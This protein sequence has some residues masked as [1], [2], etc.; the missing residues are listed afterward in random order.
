MCSNGCPKLLKQH[1]SGQPARISRREAAWASP[2]AQS[3]LAAGTATLAAVFIT[4]MADLSFTTTVTWYITDM[5][6]TDMLDMLCTM[7][8]DAKT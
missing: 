4:D 2:S 3:M 6:H 8:T 5:L 1:R 7:T